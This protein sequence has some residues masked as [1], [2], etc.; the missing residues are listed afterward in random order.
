MFWFL[1]AKCHKSQAD[2]VLELLQA[3]KWEPVPLPRILDLRPR[4]AHHT[5]CIRELRERG[6]D[7]QCKSWFTDMYWDKV[8]MS[9]YTFNGI[10]LKPR[11]KHKKGCFTQEDMDKNYEA[12]Y[13]ACRVQY[14]LIPK[15]RGRPLG[16]KNK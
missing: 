8:H 1:K 2:R 11:E 6:Y 4:I 5:E 9:E 16:S 14:D 12:W 10:S 13:Q 7:I 3:H 15:K